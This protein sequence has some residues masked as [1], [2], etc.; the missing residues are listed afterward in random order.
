MN[1]IPISEMSLE[2]LFGDSLTS[3]FCV[4][5]EKSTETWVATGML[6]QQLESFTDAVVIRENDKPI[7]PEVALYFEYQLYRANRTTKINAEQF[8]A[9]ASLNYP[10]LAISGVYLNFNRGAIMPLTD[11]KL[12]IRKQLDTNITILKLFPGITEVNV[13]NVLNIKNIKGVILETYGS[14]NAPT[15]TWFIKL[16]KNTIEKGIYIVNVTQCSGGSVNLGL[17]ETSTQL[18]NIGII[19]GKDIT[20]ESAVAKFFYLLSL[21]IPKKDFKKVFETSL[22]GEIT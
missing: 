3:S 13:K 10:P 17:Y 11:K 9:F 22:R 7:V 1:T 16:L 19:D 12:I 14:G 21:N 18:K 20:T 2:S 6:V 15:A 5:I 4:N 8:E